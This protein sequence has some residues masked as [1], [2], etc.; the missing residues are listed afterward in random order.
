[1]IIIM[2]LLPQPFHRRVNQLTPVRRLCILSHF[3]E[4]GRDS[5]LTHVFQVTSWHNF[6]ISFFKMALREHRISDLLFAQLPQNPFSY[7]FSATH[8]VYSSQLNDN[9][10]RIFLR[11]LDMLELSTHLDSNTFPGSRASWTESRL[12]NQMDPDLDPQFIPRFGILNLM[13][14]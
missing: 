10:D 9:Y 8:T 6:L 12:W 2:R 1:M 13:N 11:A 7:A 5:Q 4:E 3:G 14:T